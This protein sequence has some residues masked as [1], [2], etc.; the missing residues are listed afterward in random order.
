[1]RRTNADPAPDLAGEH[2]DL[3]EGTAKLLDFGLAKP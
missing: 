1:M 3:R 2:H